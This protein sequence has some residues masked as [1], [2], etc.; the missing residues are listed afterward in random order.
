METLGVV[1][2]AVLHE[3]RRQST[4]Q[5]GGE[6]LQAGLRV[7]RGSEACRVFE[8]RTDQAEDQ[9]SGDIRTAVQVDGAD[10]GFDRV[11]EDRRFVG[12]PGEL[13]AATE[14]DVSTESDGACDFS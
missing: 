7:H 14:L 6:L 11:G 4:T 12:G 3:I 5:P 1:G 8:Q 10:D 2:T 13:V 9:R